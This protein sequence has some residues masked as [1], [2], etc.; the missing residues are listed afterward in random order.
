MGS[1][2]HS[3]QSFA[4]RWLR[5]SRRLGLVCLGA[6]FCLQAAQA[7]NLVDALTLAESADPAWREAQANALA[8]AEGIPQAKAALW[9]PTLA[10]TAGGSHADQSITTDVNI[11][12]GGDVA[13][14][15][16]D[17]RLTL[18]QP[19]FNQER[20]VRL[21]Q[22]H[23][24]VAQAQ[25][26]LDTAYQDLILRVA[27][28]YFA[29]LAARDDIAFAKAE[30]EALGGQLDQAKQR[31][32]VGLIAITDV[33]EA[34]AGF[35]RSQAREIAA[36][37]ALEIAQEE[38]REITGT[39]LN[40]LIP[41]GETMSLDRPTPDSIEQWT[42]SALGRNLEIAAAQAAT[43]IAMEEIKAQQAGHYPSLDI[44]GSRGL[45][46][47]GGRFGQTEVDGG[48]IGMRVNIPL[49][50]GGSVMSRTREA[51]HSHAA[52]LER[53]ERARRAAYRQTREAFLG[54]LSQISA[55]TALAQ[56]VRSSAT[57]VDSTRAGFEVGTRTTID[58]VTAERGLSQARRDY[59]MARYE[60]TLN[61]L[62]LKRAAGTLAPADI[63]ATNEWLTPTA[64]SGSQ[65][66]R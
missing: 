4:R 35:D 66:S 22:A 43:E 6:T 53:L 3:P 33:Q 44:S 50:A 30:K 62:R 16:Y 46:S 13:F 14:Q 36:L 15:N 11:G 29:V 31:F 64:S 56:A 2:P 12:L 65:T 52:A 17:Y 61:R 37:N 25:A 47:Q 9:F 34:Q 24:R 23:K 1:H 58:V 60:Y 40:D 20:Y 49:Y 19:V 8:V 42:E 26:E 48:D 10:F 21:R 5:A 45:T 41:L 59:A 27:E 55:V 51:T 28:R 39:Y 57:A 18:T 32:E 54:I 7:T 38:L 63:A